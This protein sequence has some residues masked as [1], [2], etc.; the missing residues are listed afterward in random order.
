MDYAL[1]CVLNFT[2]YIIL[3]YLSLFMYHINVLYRKER[4]KL[5]LV[6]ATTFLYLFYS[7]LAM[8]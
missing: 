5:Y 1:Y 4:K 3:H 7:T 8:I 6:G 2:M